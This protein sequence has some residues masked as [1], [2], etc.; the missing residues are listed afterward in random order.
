MKVAEIDFC[1]SCASKVGVEQSPRGTWNLW[2]LAPANSCRFIPWAIEE[3][4]CESTARDSWRKTKAAIVGKMFG[5]VQAPSS[6]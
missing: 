5:E 3:H 1:P 6:L 2:H 4:L